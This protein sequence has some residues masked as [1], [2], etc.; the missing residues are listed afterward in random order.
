[1][2]SCCC[3]CPDYLLFLRIAFDQ[4]LFGICRSFVMFVDFFVFICSSC[5][6]D[7]LQFSLCAA[8][9]KDL[10][11]PGLHFATALADYHI[12]SATSSSLC[13]NCWLR[14]MFQHPHEVASS[15]PN[16][17]PIT[18]GKVLAGFFS[19]GFLNLGL[20]NPQGFTGRFPGVLGWKLSF[21]VFIAI[22]LYPVLE[23]NF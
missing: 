1:M 7:F 12:S 17:P 10:C 2:S 6:P 18:A 4:F 8:H 11:D 14:P 13:W 15:G 3:F 9:P 23:E 20:A 22:F 19:P 21:H 5:V 16:F